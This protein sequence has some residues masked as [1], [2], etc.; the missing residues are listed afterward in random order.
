MLLG[1]CESR[2]LTS[3]GFIALG[4]PGVTLASSQSYAVA[5]V[6][7]GRRAADLLYAVLPP[8]VRSDKQRRVWLT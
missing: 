3:C 4:A 2:A 7:E 5:L 1:S 6:W 8:R